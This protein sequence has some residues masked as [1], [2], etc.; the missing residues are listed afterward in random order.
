MTAAFLMT[1]D[2]LHV[3]DPILLGGLDRSATFFSDLLSLAFPM[4]T[5]LPGSSQSRARWQPYV[6]NVSEK[7]SIPKQSHDAL[8][9]VVHHIVLS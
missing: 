4:D 9:I 7:H 2:T 8:S 3:L 6:G 1:M 5:F